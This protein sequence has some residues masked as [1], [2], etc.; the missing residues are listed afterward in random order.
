M[1]ALEKPYVALQRVIV[2]PVDGVAV[3]IHSFS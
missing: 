3:Q 1:E 2:G